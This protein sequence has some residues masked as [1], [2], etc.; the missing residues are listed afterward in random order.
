MSGEIVGRG[1]IGVSRDEQSVR[2]PGCGRPRAGSVVIF[3][4]GFTIWRCVNPACPE[5]PDV[6]DER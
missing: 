2:C 3:G 6:E 1:E 4:H 5:G